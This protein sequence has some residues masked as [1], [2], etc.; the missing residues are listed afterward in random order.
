ML[1]K[2]FKFEMKS[3]FRT[4]LFAYGAFLICT[5]L[6]AISGNV[7][8]LTEFTAMYRVD[9]APVA[10]PW[11]ELFFLIVLLL[12]IATMMIVVTVTCVNIIRGYRRSMYAREAYLIHT[13]PI[14]QWQLLLVKV[15]SALVWIFLSVL[16]SFISLLILMIAGCITQG[17]D[18]IQFFSQLMN[19][20][21]SYPEVVVE[22]M[23]QLLMMLCSASSMITLIYCIINFTYSS[24]VHHYRTMIGILLFV[25]ISIIYSILNHA[26]TQMGILP[27]VLTG[28]SFSTVLYDIG[29]S[30]LWFTLSLYLLKHHMEVE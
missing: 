2:F 17:I 15:V 26:L 24:F 28:F 8:F 13:L 23:K 21:F 22:I 10:T 9:I 1:W 19:M 6:L 30:A 14:E 12:Y 29:L 4:Y 11:L 20:L 25:V 3:S 5:L 27:A 7:Q 18:I 16:I